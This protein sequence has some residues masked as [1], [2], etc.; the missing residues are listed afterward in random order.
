M[1]KQLYLE[2]AEQLKSIKDE[3]G[4]SKIKH[5]DL[6]NKQV[7]FIEEEQPF[8]FPAVFIEFGEFPWRSQGGRVQDAQITM[9]LHILTRAEGG[10]ADGSDFQD[11]ALAYLD[12][13][14]DINYAL[15]GFSGSCFGSISRTRSIPNHD[16]GEIIEGVEHFS[17]LVIDESAVRKTVK[18]TNVRPDIKREGEG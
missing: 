1:R 4:L 2:L 5:T 12:L 16:H 7:E 6:W 17:M 9:A 10:T 3:A 15:D 18:V 14:G 8:D 11:D 13:P